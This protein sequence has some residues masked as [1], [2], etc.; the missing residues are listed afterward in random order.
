[1]A[2][3]SPGRRPVGRWRWGE[4]LRLLRATLDRGGLLAVP[5][6]SSYGLA[7]DPR[8]ARGVEAIYRLKGRE[9]GRPLPIVAANLEQLAALGVT[10]DDPVFLRVAAI[11]PAP[12]SLVVP[13][14]RGLPAGAGGDTLAVRLPRYR[15]L[16]RLLDELGL[17]LTATSAN[18]TGEPPVT[19]PADLTELLAGRDAVIV[20]D[21]RLSGGPPSTILALGE[22]GLTV[23][24]HGGYPI[25]DLRRLVPDLSMP[26]A[27]DER[28]RSP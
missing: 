5:T 15:A 14:L 26:A 9:R 21:G 24:R 13:A 4:S 8:D 3:G 27:R 10:V 1:M 16:L 25:A 2:A 12:L 7:V 23:L 18:R 28:P 22:D 19:D 11:W 6:E 17:A 20:D